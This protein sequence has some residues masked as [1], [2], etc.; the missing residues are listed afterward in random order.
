MGS[1]L[2]GFDGW[3]ASWPPLVT[4]LFVILALVTSIAPWIY[5]LFNRHKG[6][7][8]V[9]AL[10]ADRRD[11]RAQI[12]KLKHRTNVLARA[13]ADRDDTPN[14]PDSYVRQGLSAEF[15]SD[16][17]RPAM[18]TADSY[19]HDDEIDIHRGHILAKKPVKRGPP[20]LPPTVLDDYRKRAVNE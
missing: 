19:I 11:L 13:L 17:A 12:K 15:K 7:R 6:L 14:S 9:A 2:N 3:V 4:L 5:V 16:G 20:V 1:I 18:V 8:H 10:E